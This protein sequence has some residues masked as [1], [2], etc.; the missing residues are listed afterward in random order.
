MNIQLPSSVSG[1]KLNT[2]TRTDPTDVA[3]TVHV[4][5]FVPVNPFEVTA[6]T[7]EALNE[8]VTAPVF[9]AS[10]AVITIKGTY[11]A[12]V[13]FEVSDDSGTTWFAVDAGRITGNAI[14]NNSGNLTNT[15]RAW[16]L[17]IVGFTHLRVRCS[18]YT[19]GSVVVRISPSQVSVDPAPCIPTHSINGLP[20]AAAS[21]DALTNPTVTQIGAL[22][23]KYNGATWDRVRPN[24]NVTTGDTGAKTAT[25]AGATQTNHNAR[26]AVV[27][28]NVGAVT[29]TSPTLAAKLQ[30]SPDGGTTWV[31]VP[32]ASLPN[33]TA[34]GV[35]TLTV[36]P[37]AGAIAN[38]VVNFPL[39]RTWRVYYTIGG[40]TPSFTLTNVQVAYVL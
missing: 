21:A 25:F 9:D 24:T 30:M 40:T 33:I 18:A 10:S 29:G 6:G 12:T 16:E 34:T 11:V 38:S 28:L 17:C 23:L 2:Y 4:Q 1:A 19:S 13:A 32:G 22:A 8:A 31:D 36:Y 35:Y 14:E 5:S 37:G 39:P 3:S 20:T 15:A 26:G 27:T 7:L